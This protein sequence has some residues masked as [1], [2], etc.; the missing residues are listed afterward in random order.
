MKVNGQIKGV[1]SEVNDMYKLFHDKE[2]SKND[3][4][5]I[6]G[7]SLLQETGGYA[8]STYLKGIEHFFLPLTFYAL[9]DHCLVYEYTVGLKNNKSNL[10]GIKGFPSKVF[11]DLNLLAKNSVQS[12]ILSSLK[13]VLLNNMKL[14]EFM[15]AKKSDFYQNF[16]VLFEYIHNILRERET[17]LNKKLD[18]QL[19]N[20][21]YFGVREILFNENVHEEE[22]DLSVYSKVIG[23]LYLNQLLD[24]VFV[25]EW[26]KLTDFLLHF[27]LKKIQID[28]DLLLD[29]IIRSIK[30]EKPQWIF[31]K[32]PGVGVWDAVFPYQEIYRLINS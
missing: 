5:L 9:L 22:I 23:Y 1:I 31:L 3:L 28:S 25:D 20:H 10:L 8:A 19:A 14:W 2:L 27:Q 15:Y 4:L 29:S 26:K 24:S 30:K 17:L 16:Q 13:Y 32:K 7:D 12:L 11:C 21:L 6:I 18:V